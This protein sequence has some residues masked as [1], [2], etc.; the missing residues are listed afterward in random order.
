MRI[1]ITVF[2]SFTWLTEPFRTAPS[3]LK[4]S[5][6]LQGICL[7]LNSLF[8]WIVWQPLLFK[9]EHLPPLLCFI[10]TF[11]LRVILEF[12]LDTKHFLCVSSSRVRWL[13]GERR[14]AVRGVGPQLLCGWRF[15]SGA[16][17]RCPAKPAGPVHP[18][19]QCTRRWH[20]TGGS[21][22]TSCSVAAHSQ[23]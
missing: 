2:S 8:L 19:A 7:Y 14:R 18:R 15:K 16:P 17:A 13:C 1:Q 9:V 21:H 11:Q 10:W 20:G 3:F 5:V 12:C 23:G 4:V 22:W 6:Y